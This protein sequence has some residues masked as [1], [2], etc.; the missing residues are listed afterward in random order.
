MNSGS[1][2]PETVEQYIAQFPEERQVVLNKLRAVVKETAPEATEAILYGMPG[3]KLNGPLAYFGAFKEHV[4]F[5]PI[6][7]TLE[8]F[9]EDLA[10]Y[11]SSK[12]GVQFPYDD[13]PYKLVKRMVKYRMKVN[14][15]N[16]NK[17]R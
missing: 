11:K 17:Y 3:Y 10:K 2:S 14:A 13:V 6:P 5:Y 9:A 12:G 1:G 4:G 8:E 16:P 15:E 7:A